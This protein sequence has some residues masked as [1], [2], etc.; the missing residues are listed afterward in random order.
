MLIARLNTRANL[1]KT[2]LPYGKIVYIPSLWH[3]SA[4]KTRALTRFTIANA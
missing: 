2:S 4:S 1:F 3:A